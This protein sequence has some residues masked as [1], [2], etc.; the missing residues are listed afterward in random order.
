MDC[1]RRAATELVC[2]PQQRRSHPGPVLIPT[3]PLP[4]TVLRLTE[5]R[6]EAAQFLECGGKPSA[7]P[8]WISP[9]PVLG[10]N[11]KRR[12][13]FALPAHYKMR[14]CD[15]DCASWP[16]SGNSTRLE[17]PFVLRLTEPQ[18][19]AGLRRLRPAAASLAPRSCANPNLS[20]ACH[21]AAAHR[22]ALLRMR[23]FRATNY[24]VVQPL[25]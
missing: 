20:V 6:S 13:R 16:L 19:S 17:N 4:A 1:Y 21:G 23:L 12:R 15:P 25:R 22:A 3:H 24:Q 5:P 14:V 7:T 10:P 8:L 9:E 11:P 2:D 18:R